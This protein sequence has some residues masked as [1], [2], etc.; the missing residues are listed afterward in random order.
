[1]LIVKIIFT[2]KAALKNKKNLKNS[3][4]NVVIITKY[5]E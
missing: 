4:N 5:L 2:I 3:E 1:M